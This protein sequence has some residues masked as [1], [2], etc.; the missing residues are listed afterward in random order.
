MNFKQTNKK[1]SIIPMLN[2][3]GL[4]HW[5]DEN[6][7]KKNPHI[8]RISRNLSMMTMSRLMVNLQRKATFETKGRQNKNNVRY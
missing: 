7:F 3:V 2:E 8:N 5:E 1:L 6:K 4:L